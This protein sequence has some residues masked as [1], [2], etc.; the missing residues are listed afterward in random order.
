MRRELSDFRPYNTIRSEKSHHSAEL[1]KKAP[2]EYGLMAEHL[3]HA[4]DSFI[5]DITDTFNQISCDKQ[6][7]GA[8]KTGI[9]TRV[10][11]NVV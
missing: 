3:K 1:K 8:F 2:D 7:P 10:L 5:E 4:G 6:A 9:L 11:K